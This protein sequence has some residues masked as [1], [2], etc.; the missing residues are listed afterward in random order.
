MFFFIIGAE[1]GNAILPGDYYL[2]WKKGIIP[3][4]VSDDCPHKARLRKAIAHWNSKRVIRL[5]ERKRKEEDYVVFVKNEENY[6]SSKR[7]RWGGKQYIY[8]AS[9]VSEG[10][11]IHEIGHTVGLVHEHN[12]SDRDDH[13]EVLWD[14]LVK[15]SDSEFKE[16]REDIQRLGKYDINSVMHYSSYTFAAGEEPTM[17]TKKGAL[18]P[19]N[20][21]LSRGDVE[22]VKALYADEIKP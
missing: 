8:L 13:I 9:E 14:N 10:T 16:S 6:S 11:I 2:L 21:V 7:G 22:A 1:A 5:I 19:S 17:K 12:R 20:E 18:I 4:E 15:D 3:F